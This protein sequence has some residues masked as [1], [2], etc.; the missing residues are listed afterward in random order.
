C[1]SS[2][3]V[4][5]HEDILITV[6]GVLNLKGKLPDGICWDHRMTRP[7]RIERLDLHHEGN[8]VVVTGAER[9]AKVNMLDSQFAIGRVGWHRSRGWCKSAGTCDLDIRVETGGGCRTRR[10]DAD[11]AAGWAFGD[12]VD[13]SYSIKIVRRGISGLIKI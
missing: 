11:F 3:R 4:H 13:R 12:G 10:S 2:A 5:G 1:W 7:A 9:L 8:R 6:R